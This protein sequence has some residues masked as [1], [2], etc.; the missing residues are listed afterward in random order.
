MDE[1]LLKKYPHAKR[2]LEKTGLTIDA[3]LIAVDIELKKLEGGE[4]QK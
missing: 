1:T 3:A 4:I 2:Y